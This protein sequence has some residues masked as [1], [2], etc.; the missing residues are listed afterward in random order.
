LELRG[1]PDKVL[2]RFRHP[3]KKPIRSVAIDGRAHRIFDAKSG[4]VELP[5]VSGKM[6]VNVGY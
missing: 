5:P 3:D 2:L 1:K 6:R 4:D